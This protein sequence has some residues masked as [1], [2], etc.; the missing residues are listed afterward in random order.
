MA[1]FIILNASQADAVRGPSA[2]DPLSALNPIAR[3]GNLFILPVAVL[4]DP[5]HVAHID[6]LSALPQLASDAEG[7]PAEADEEL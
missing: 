4:D 3:Q 1:T 6:F 5:A 2:I 7:F